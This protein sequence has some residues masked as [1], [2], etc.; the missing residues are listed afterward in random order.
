MKILISDSLEAPCIDHLRNEGFEVDNRP[1][2]SHNDLIASIGS[3]DALIVR[4]ATKVT[5]DVIEHAA[6][7]KVIGRAGTGVDN[8]DANNISALRSL[9]RRWV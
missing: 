7:L 3:Y 5:A 8:I 2:L 9:K 6:H 4:S 1:G